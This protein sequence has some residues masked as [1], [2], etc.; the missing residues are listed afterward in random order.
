MKNIKRIEIPWLL[1]KNMFFSKPGM[2]TA[3]REERT[4]YRISIVAEFF[5]KIGFN[6]KYDLYNVHANRVFHGEVIKV[7]FYYQESAANFYKKLN[8]TRDGKTSDIRI[9]KKIVS[10]K[11][12]SI[13]TNKKNQ[14]NELQ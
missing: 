13:P 11:N 12:Q 2:N 14:K 9:I 10:Q 5:K 8:T 3:K 7:H 4:R 6:V 1:S